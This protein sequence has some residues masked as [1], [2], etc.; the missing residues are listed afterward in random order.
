MD[1]EMTDGIPQAGRSSAGRGNLEFPFYLGSLGAWYGGLGLQ[2]VLFPWLVA[3][4]LEAPAHLVGIAQTALMAPAIVFILLGGAVADHNDGRTLLIRYHLLAAAPPIL[5]AVAILAGA[6]S[7][8]AIVVFGLAMGTLGAFAMPA[9]D[10]L[11]VHVAG[12]NLPRA[13]A[14]VTGAQFLAQ[15]LGMIGASLAET[16]TAPVLLCGQAVI[17][18]L[19]AVACWRLTPAPPSN[20]PSTTSRFAAII[21]GVREAWSIPVVWPVIVAMMGIGVFYIGA[22][23]V[24]LPVIIRDDYGGSAT[25]I[26]IVNFFFW[27][28]ALASIFAQVRLGALRRPGRAMLIS[29]LVAAFVLLALSQRLPFYG[30]ASLCGIW[31]V[32]AGVNMTQGRTLV[33]IA[34]PA[35]HRARILSLFQLGFMGGAPIGAFLV[36]FIAKA[37]DVHL[38]TIPPALVMICLLAFLALRSTLWRH[39]AIGGP[40]RA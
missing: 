31:G 29:L 40:V 24:L 39:Q 38:A 10:A 2:M 12:A 7:F 15:L 8:P 4:V 35:S 30:L 27:G 21:D 11:L 19:G 26:A 28:G 17:M 34:A 6:L 1:S 25:E 18:A 5:L 3:V 22:F 9:R 33:Q 32:T 20:A 36:G 23:L 14:L 37:T 13:V 16:L